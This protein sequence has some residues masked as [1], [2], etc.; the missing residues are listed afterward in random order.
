[1]C[2]FSPNADIGLID[3]DGFC[4][5]NAPREIARLT[6][7]EGGTIGM[8]GDTPCDLH[9]MYESGQSGLAPYS[10]ARA[11][12]MLLIELLCFDAT[13]SKE[14][15]PEKWPLQQVEAK[16]QTSSFHQAATFFGSS[17]VLSMPENQRQS[18]ADILRCLR[19]MASSLSVS[20]VK[21][22]PTNRP[23]IPAVD[24]R[25]SWPVNRTP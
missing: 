22:H 21:T 23:R 12:D 2:Q 11:R 1:M 13:F 4:A 15:P 3:F 19:G 9:Q 17:S 6:E 14:A 25:T 24:K 10:D 5:P 20:G 16:L 8:E 7:D 18:S